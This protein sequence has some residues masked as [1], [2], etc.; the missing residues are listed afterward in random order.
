[1]SSSYVRCYSPSTVQDLFAQRFLY[2]F[3]EDHIRNIFSRRKVK[4]KS[5]SL[6]PHRLLLVITRVKITSD[7]YKLNISCKERNYR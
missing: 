2:G 3:E 5:L 4:C 7:L 6:K 1:M